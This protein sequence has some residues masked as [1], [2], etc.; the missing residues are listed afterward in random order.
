[1][2][3]SMS[4]RSAP[5]FWDNRRERSVR[6]TTPVLNINVL[7]ADKLCKAQDK[8]NR[9]AARVLPP[10]LTD[11]LDPGK[12]TQEVVLPCLPTNASSTHYL[13]STLFFSMH[14]C[15]CEAPATS[16]P[17]PVR[18]IQNDTLDWGAPVASRAATHTFRDST[19]NAEA[20]VA[21]PV[22]AKGNLQL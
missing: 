21:S 16:S 5:H 20:G 8:V 6:K 3:S 12:L 19:L 18:S 1:V 10:E 17:H 2:A 15:V 22:T 7:C 13:H 11:Q 9:P 4:C 14:G